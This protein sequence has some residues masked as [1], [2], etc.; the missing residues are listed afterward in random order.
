MDFLVA[1]WSIPNGRIRKFLLLLAIPVALLAY[2]LGVDPFWCA[3]LA[4]VILWMFPHLFKGCV[5]NCLVPTATK[6]SSAASPHMTRALDF[7]RKEDYDRAIVEYGMAIS[8][9]RYHVSAYNLRG[10]LFSLKKQHDYAIV[11]Y[12]SAINIAPKLVGLGWRISD[13]LGDKLASAYNGRGDAYFAKEQFDLAIDDFSA[14]IAHLSVLGT[15]KAFQELRIDD[16]VS[17]SLSRAF[18]YRGRSYLAIDDYESAVVDFAS[19]ISV[20]PDKASEYDSRFVV[21]AN[22]ARDRGEYDLAILGYTIGIHIDPDDT[23]A[24]VTGPGNYN[25]RGLAHLAKGEYD[26]A[27]ADFET[28]INID[29]RDWL[30]H[31]N[32]GKAYIAKSG[33]GSP[34]ILQAAQP[35]VA[36]EYD[37][38]MAAYNAGIGG[39]PNN[40]SGYMNRGLAYL[41]KGDFKSA[42]ADLDTAIRIAPENRMAYKNRIIRQMIQHHENGDYDLAIMADTIAIGI[43]PDD[44][45]GYHN[46]GLAYFAKGEY[47]SAIADFET[48]IRIGP[49]SMASEACQNRDRAHRAKENSES[50]Q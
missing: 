36:G 10:G 4:V 20:E 50:G 34:V 47:D 44:S 17:Y 14:A 49:A 9:D 37:L 8:I 12:T 18:D 43:D 35:R 23:G 2:F 26:L 3:A 32:L 45:T 5:K 27:I 16:D 25:G 22:G 11:D 48:V 15:V 41:A 29:P 40:A 21:W 39:D 33:H 46:R 30:V 6:N 38:A 31:E 13:N 1:A 19:A 28:A 42:N 24:Y 7:H